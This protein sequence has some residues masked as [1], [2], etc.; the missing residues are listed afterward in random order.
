[1]IKKRDTHVLYAASGGT[2]AEKFRLRAVV[3]IHD[4][5]DFI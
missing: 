4:S 1:M 3:Y 5:P 2:G